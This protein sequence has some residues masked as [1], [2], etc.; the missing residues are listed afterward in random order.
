MATSSTSSYKL[1]PIQS[2]NI[3]RLTR[4]EYPAWI[5]WWFAVDAVL[6]LFPPL[7][8]AM[9]GRDP[10]VLGLPISVFYFALTGLCITVS[11]VAAYL[12]ESRQGNFDGIGV[13]DAR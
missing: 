10:L 2:T 13:G 7:Y 9:S 11:V 8:W 12:V 5:K 4:P 1:P 3:P 6:A